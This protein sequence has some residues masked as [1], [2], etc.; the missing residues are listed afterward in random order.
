M[1]QIYFKEINGFFNSLIG[2]IVAGVFLLS[3]GMI[4]WVFPD[5]SILYYNYASLE[6]FFYIVPVVFLFLIPAI[7]MSMFAGESKSGTLELLLTKPLTP[8]Q[9]VWGKV[10][11]SLTLVL[12]VL[13]PTLIYYYSVYQLGAPKGNLDTG[14]IIGSYIGLVL[15]AFVFVSIGVF[16]SALTESQIVAFLLATLLSISW[17]W[18]FGLLS[19]VPVFSGIWDDL[20]A[21][22]GIDAHYHSI[23]RGV[24]DTRDVLY[25]ISLALAFVWAT[26]FV[27]KMKRN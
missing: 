23:R 13:L 21:S 1:M 6:S 18:G 19:K 10:L 12:I 2:Y 11:S 27:L 24:V 4:L 22:F 8:A 3:L 7:T 9:I 20:I 5:Y 17:Y 26:I 15:L 16:A 14:G 25:F